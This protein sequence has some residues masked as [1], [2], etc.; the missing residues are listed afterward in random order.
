MLCDAS[1]LTDERPLQA[2]VCIVGAGA[3]GI[4]MALELAG[5]K[6][7]VILIESG[8]HEDEKEIQALYEGSVT[9]E[10]LH[11]LPDRY[12]RRRFGGST[13]VWGGRCTPLDEIDFKPR[14]YIPFSGWPIEPRDL[15][16]YYPKAN[17]LCEAGDFLYTAAESFSSAPRPMI[18]G[19][20]GTSFCTEKLERFSCPTDFAARYGHKL[21]TAKNVR[22][23]LHANATRLQLDPAGTRLVELTAATLAGKRFTV[24]ATYFVLATGGL[25]IPRLLLANNDVQPNGIGNDRDVVGRYYMCHLAGTMGRLQINGSADT[26]WNGY[27]ITDDGIYCRRRLA[28]RAEAQEEHRIGNFIAR[29]HHPRIA[30]PEHRHA[31]LS[32]LYASQLLIPYEYRRRLLEAETPGVGT[33]LRHVRNIL[34]GPTEAAAFAWHM[35]NDRFLAERKFP[36]IVV[37]SKTNVFSLDFHAEQIPNPLS[38]I[39][40]TSTR[41]ALGL[42]RL[43]VDWR[44][45]PDDVRTVSTSMALLARDVESSGVG[46]LTYEPENVE[47]E[48]TRY[49]AYGGHHIGTTRMG[50][51]PRTSVVDPDCRVHGVDNLYIAGASVFPTSSQANPTLTVVALALRLASHL[52]LRVAS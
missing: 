32:L 49:G 51:D 45:T 50:V 26:V 18:R 36:S 42:P 41:D 19:F 5:S 33:W 3:A 28:L 1:E 38:R 48:M 6:L 4:T 2:D 23:I 34:T 13:S 12:R 7:D 44:Y 11:N 21:R 16:P 22:L 25:E 37:R 17:R 10:R 47:L 8:G 24:R 31:V 40:L 9:D 43:N 20:S 46:R 30:D 52:T 15:L 14:D 35:V 29:L 39:T 27:D